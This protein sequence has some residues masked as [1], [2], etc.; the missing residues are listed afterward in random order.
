[1]VHPI[2]F[3][4]TMDWDTTI[5]QEPLPGTIVGDLNW[6]SNECCRMVLLQPLTRKPITLLT[7]RHFNWWREH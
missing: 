2:M 7:E 3:A 6:N 1:M 4:G 5:N